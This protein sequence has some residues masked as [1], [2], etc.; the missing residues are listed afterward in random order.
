MNDLSAFS[1][2]AK[3]K[4]C[5]EISVLYAYDIE[6]MEPI[7]AEVFPRNST[8]AASY[9]ARREKKDDFDPEKYSKK[10]EIFGVIVFESDQNL[11]PQ[12][13]YAC[14][15][16][17]WLLELVFNRYKSDECPDK[18]DVQGDFS[19]IGSKPI[20]KPEPKKKGRPRKNPVEDKPKRPR[21]RPRKNP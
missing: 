15:D 2:K 7:C 16:D 6:A 11:D 10:Q 20:P 9:L 12:T 8:D 4:G 3:K 1:Y 21:G 5:Q 18:T 19:V 17:R 13:A 14:Y